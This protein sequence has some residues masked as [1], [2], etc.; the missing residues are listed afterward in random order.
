MWDG[1]F[2]AGREPRFQVRHISFPIS[3]LLAYKKSIHVQRA[4]INVGKDKPLFFFICPAF[5]QSEK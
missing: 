4:V 5:M 1:T 3:T 2:Y